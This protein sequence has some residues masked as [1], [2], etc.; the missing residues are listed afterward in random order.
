MIS[1]IAL[2]F[3]YSYKKLVKS[4]LPLNYLADSLS[5]A[6]TFMAGRSLIMTQGQMELAYFMMATLIFFLIIPIKDHGDSNGDAKSGIK[7]FYTILDP[8]KAFRL[9]K[10]LLCAAFVI[11]S[12]CFLYVMPF[13]NLWSITIFY[14]IPSVV[15][16]PLMVF[17]FKKNENLEMSIWLIDILLLIYLIPFLL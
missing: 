7:N 2:L 11:F 1:I 10:V 9:C 15:M 6:I 5:Y 14:V 3:L 17:I 4:V 8:K 12:L 16:L 13:K